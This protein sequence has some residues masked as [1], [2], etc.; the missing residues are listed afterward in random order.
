MEILALADQHCPFAANFVHSKDRSPFFVAVGRSHIQC[1]LF[2]CFPFSEA[3]RH[4]GQDIVSQYIQVDD[5]GRVM[6]E[7]WTFKW[8]T[9]R[10]PRTSAVQHLI[11]K[12]MSHQDNVQVENFCVCMLGG[13]LPGQMNSDRTR[14]H[15]YRGQT[16]T[17]AA[18]H[19]SAWL[20]HDPPQA[21]GRH[22]PTT[23]LFHLCNESES[24]E[25]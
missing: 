23:V 17:S 22:N 21:V 7:N 11:S 10:A 14:A 5:R 16:N 2:L 6:Q 24:L 3:K 18:K 8:R 13:G 15:R 12:V 4:A 20:S 19:W 9:S 1:I 25:S